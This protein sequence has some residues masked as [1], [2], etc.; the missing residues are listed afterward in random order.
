MR[1]ACFVGLLMLLLGCGGS[2]S[3]TSPTTAPTV[4]AP[5]ATV[6][7]T[8]P[9]LDEANGHRISD[10]LCVA[11]VPDTWVDD[12]TGR[13]STPDGAG[14]A[15]FGGRLVTSD[16]WANAS[17]LVSTQMAGVAGATVVT[18]DSDTKVTFP[19]NA[20]FSTRQRFADRYCDFSIRGSEELSAADLANGNAV[21]ASL[22]PAQS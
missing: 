8:P 13:G 14:F 4:A 15:L 12:G 22:A 20:G 16:D 6:A 18:G 19:N 10:G 2:K 1:A 3:R 9:P 11:L 21:I 7:P 5:V 17:A